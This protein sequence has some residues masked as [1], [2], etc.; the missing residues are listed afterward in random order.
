M[1]QVFG[2]ILF[3]KILTVENDYIGHHATDCGKDMN[4]CA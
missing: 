3:A 2:Q 4:I 1:L